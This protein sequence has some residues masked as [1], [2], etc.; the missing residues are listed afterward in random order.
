MIYISTQISEHHV[1][2]HPTGLPFWVREIVALTLDS[3]LCL[4][5][6]EDIL[7]PEIAHTTL[8]PVVLHRRKVYRK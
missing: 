4:Y 1:L 3:H 6:Q 5:L 8:N 7:N 2:D